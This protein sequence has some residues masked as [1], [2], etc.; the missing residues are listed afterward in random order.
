MKMDGE[1][2]LT[3][4][5]TLLIFVFKIWSGSSICL[6]M[7]WVFIVV[8]QQIVTLFSFMHFISPFDVPR[9]DEKM[10]SPY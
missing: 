3:E 2:L 7:L 10:K 4:N 1:V 6:E 5:L 8:V 9:E